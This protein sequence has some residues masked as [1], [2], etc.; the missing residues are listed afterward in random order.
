M[1]GTQRKLPQAGLRPTL[2]RK[3]RGLKQI[4]RHPARPVVLTAVVLTAVVAAGMAAAQAGIDRTN[5]RGSRRSP[6]TCRSVRR[7]ACTPDIPCTPGPGGVAA[8]Q[9]YTPARGVR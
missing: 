6:N 5:A 9:R 1:T 2:S 4:P 3:A 7:A 8:E